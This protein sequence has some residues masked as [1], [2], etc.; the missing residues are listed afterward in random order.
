MTD[1]VEQN[2]CLQSCLNPQ[3]VYLK[4]E[5]NS[6]KALTQPC[7]TPQRGLK[8]SR[9]Q[10]TEMEIRKHKS[11]LLALVHLI[12]FTWVFGL[13]LQSSETRIRLPQ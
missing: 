3:Q 9:D 5:R 12:L 8:G 7:E 4:V 13:R 11:P 10:T 1:A 6:R 2:Q